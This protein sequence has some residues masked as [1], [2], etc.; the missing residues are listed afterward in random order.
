M[1]VKKSNLQ[2]KSMWECIGRL[3]FNMEESRQKLWLEGCL[4]RQKGDSVG[5]DEVDFP[6]CFLDLQCHNS[7]TLLDGYFI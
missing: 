6:F 1:V 7:P 2:I 4:W 3:V 5:P